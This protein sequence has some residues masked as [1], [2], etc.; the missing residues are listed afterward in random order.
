MTLLTALRKI[1]SLTKPELE[2]AIQRVN[3]EL[4]YYKREV[5]T[6]YPPERMDRF[7]KP[8]IAK[9]EGWRKEFQD[10]LDSI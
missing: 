7:A 10:K 3:V 4:D 6:N 5:I 9:L 1:D 2:H 8:Y